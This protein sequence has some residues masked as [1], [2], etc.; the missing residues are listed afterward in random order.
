MDLKKRNQFKQKPRQKNETSTDWSEI[1][2]GSLPE[3]K[4]GKKIEH[5]QTQEKAPHSLLS[6]NAQPDDL[7]NKLKAAFHEKPPED[8]ELQ[9]R[10]ELDQTIRGFRKSFREEIRTGVKQEVKQISQDVAA[11]VRT[12]SGEVVTEVRQTITTIKEAAKTKR[13]EEEDEEQVE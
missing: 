7:T 13:K 3:K 6:G 2:D 8:G 10:K 4:V 5:G 1:Q 9:R 12:L 11:G